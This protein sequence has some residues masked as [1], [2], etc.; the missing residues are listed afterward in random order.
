MKEI[1]QKMI[2]VEAN[3]H[4]SLADAEYSRALGVENRGEKKNSFRKAIAHLEAA[5]GYLGPL[6]ENEGLMKKM[7]QLFWNIAETSAQEFWF[8][9]DGP[10]EKHLPGVSSIDLASTLYGLVERGKDIEKMHT[11]MVSAFEKALAAGFG[12]GNEHYIY[13]KK[14]CLGT[15]GKPDVEVF[16]SFNKRIAVWV[17]ESEGKIKKV[18]ESHFINPDG[19]ELK[20]AYENLIRERALK[21]QKDTSGITRVE[22]KVDFEKNS[23]NYMVY[24][25][26]RGSGGGGEISEYWKNLLNGERVHKA[27]LLASGE[28]SDEFANLTGQ[29]DV[30]AQLS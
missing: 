18:I 23:Y 19:I 1:L 24:R 26:K 5:I 16:R 17:K 4:M 21:R 12:N 29:Y 13:G 28:V 2:S 3:T 15:D 30:M 22:V 20:T 10:M 6:D 9:C 8:A 25:G 11:M 14:D 7:S 27:L